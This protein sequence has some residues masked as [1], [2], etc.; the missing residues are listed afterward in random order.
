MSKSNPRWMQ[1]GKAKR[2]KLKNLALP[3][4][5][6]QPSKTYQETNITN[7]TYTK[8]SS[9]EFD[10]YEVQEH[11]I[12]LWIVLRRIAKTVFFFTI[13]TLT[14]PGIRNG[15]LTISPY[16]PAVLLILN[17]IIKHSLSSLG[18]NVQVFIGSP[19]TPIT[20]YLNLAFFIAVLISLPVIVKEL[21]SFIRPGLTEVEYL[22]L[23]KLSFYALL[24]F[25]L[26]AGISYF[27]ILPVTLKILAYSGG[28]VGDDSLLQMYSLSSILN[29]L[30]WGTLG[31]GILYACP[32]LIVVL[33]N[34][35]ILTP[36][37]VTEKRREIIMII[38]IIAA[39]VTPDPTIVS[40]LI[41][42]LP[43]IGIVEIM[44]SWGYKIE[45]NKILIESK[46]VSK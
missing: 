34:L 13:I 21:M 38:F 27:V 4:V 42:S 41:L 40:M 45:L 20:V 39:F 14:I 32:I 11:L 26:G 5:S 9:I 19:L 36:D 31:G 33:V 37:Q 43:L 1:E 23:K 22:I 25:L 12:D 3:H 24:L 17:S 2:S 28:V 18:N 44:I 16:E 6:T 30:L 8:S 7:N 29:L 35:D 15:V 10:K 46:M